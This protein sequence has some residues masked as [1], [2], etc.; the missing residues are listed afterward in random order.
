[1]AYESFL[2]GYPFSPIVNPVTLASGVRSKVIGSPAG[3][4]ALAMKTCGLSVGVSGT[5]AGAGL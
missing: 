4:P 5:G 3:R 2:Y 1:M